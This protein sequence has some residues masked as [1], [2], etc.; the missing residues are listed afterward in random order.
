MVCVSS[1]NSGDS[2][3]GFY[4]LDCGYLKITIKEVRE[5]T[6]KELNKD[7]KGMNTKKSILF[8]WK[9]LSHITK[10]INDLQSF[11]RCIDFNSIKVSELYHTK[12]HKDLILGK[13][14][15]KHSV[16]LHFVNKECIRISGF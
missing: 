13:S 9:Q 4:L 6:Y 7:L 16:I 10:R 12:K 8:W 11:Y 15:W 2:F 14:N 5:M 3:L 1:Q